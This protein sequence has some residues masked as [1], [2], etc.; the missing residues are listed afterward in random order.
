MGFE[1]L[2][3][4]RFSETVKLSGSYEGASSLAV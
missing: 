1:T 2:F 3:K 4:P